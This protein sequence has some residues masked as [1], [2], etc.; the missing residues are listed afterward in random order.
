MK[1]RE[2]FIIT[3][4]RIIAHSIAFQGSM[5]LIG[6]YYEKGLVNRFILH[7]FAFPTCKSSN[8]SFQINLQ[9]KKYEIIF[10]YY[11]KYSPLGAFYKKI[12]TFIDFSIIL[13][14]SIDLQMFLY[15]KIKKLFFSIFLNKYKMLYIPA[16]RFFS[17]QSGRLR[18]R[19]T[20]ILF[21]ITQTFIQKY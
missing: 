21:S 7:S 20:I 11:H 18:S 5:A 12:Y 8:D 14:L 13:L 16:R 10:F 9:Q 1:Y 6:L 15:H 3:Q 19:L 17:A 4:M 2:L